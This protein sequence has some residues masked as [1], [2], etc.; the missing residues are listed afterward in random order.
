MKR[1]YW[2]IL[3]SLLFITLMILVKLN[4]LSILDNSIYNL[5]TFKMNDTLNLLFKG[6]TFLGSTFFIIF[7]VIFFLVLFIVK[8]DNK[9]GY[10]VAFTLIVSTILNNVIKIIIRRE[11]PEVLALVTEKT[12]SF[13][14]GHT[15]ASVSLY[16]I[17]LYL[18]LRS[19]LNK[20]LKI[21]L[22]IILSLLPILIGISRIYL[23]A[24]FASDVIGGLLLSTILLLTL[25]LYV[26]KKNSL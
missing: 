13:P 19:N 12:F 6:I 20:K 24:H 15:M 26:D 17:L 22:G 5:V 23:G 25:T 9:K 4:L 18:V 1:K 14:S 2:I 10:L 21:S 7:L 3:C 16:G 11:R 8:K